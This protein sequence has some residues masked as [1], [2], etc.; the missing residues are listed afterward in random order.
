VANFEF[1]SLPAPLVVSQCVQKEPAFS[2]GLLFMWGVLLERHQM[3]AIGC[4]FAHKKEPAISAGL[5]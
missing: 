4:I 3:A 1:K 5:L 2:A